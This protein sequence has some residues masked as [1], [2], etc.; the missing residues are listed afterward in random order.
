MSHSHYPSVSCEFVSDTLVFLNPRFFPHS[1][2]GNADNEL[3]LLCVCV[4]VRSQRECCGISQ[5]FTLCV[6]LAALIGLCIVRSFKFPTVHIVNS[7]RARTNTHR[8]R[9]NLTHSAARSLLCKNVDYVGAPS[10]DQTPEQ[11][12]HG[13]QVWCEQ[14]VLRYLCLLW[15]WGKKIHRERTVP[16]DR[17]SLKELCKWCTAK[18]SALNAIYTAH[19]TQ[20]RYQGAQVE[21]NYCGLC[22]YIYQCGTGRIQLDC[23]WLVCEKQTVCAEI[24]FAREI[25]NKVNAGRAHSISLTL[26]LTKLLKSI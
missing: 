26:S 4:C 24:P 22:I 14:E 7:A 23:C 18:K 17:N 9:L 11:R 5:M 25:K 3:K 6:C 15:H 12:P 13:H 10:R 16:T 1:V 8:V 2:P 19:L 20:V 21:Q